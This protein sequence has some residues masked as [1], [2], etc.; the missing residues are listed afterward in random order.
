MSGRVCTVAGVPNYP[1]AI[2]HTRNYV[3]L[4]IFNL[5]WAGTQKRGKSVKSNIVVKKNESNFFFHLKFSIE[6][7]DVY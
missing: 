2:V 1:K 7:K 4:N 3:P 5:L 6:K